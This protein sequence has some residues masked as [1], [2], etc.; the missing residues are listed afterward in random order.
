MILK[1]T[2]K[3]KNSCEGCPMLNLGRWDDLWFCNLNMGFVSFKK[4][5]LHRPRP[6]KCKKFFKDD[7]AVHEW[8]G[9]FPN[10]L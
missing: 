2:L 4:E 9:S 5:E 6:D 7:K 1:I 10:Q 3:N 8:T